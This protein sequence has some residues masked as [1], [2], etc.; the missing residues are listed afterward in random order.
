MA[1]I[2]RVE[3]VS[4]RTA[5]VTHCDGLLKLL[6]GASVKSQGA[7]VKSKVLSPPSY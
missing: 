3:Q 1:V 4:F 5:S 7:S 2:G 6:S